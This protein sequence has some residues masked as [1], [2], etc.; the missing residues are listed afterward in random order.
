[1]LQQAM[2]RTRQSDNEEAT[3]TKEMKE[4][5]VNEKGN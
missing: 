5:N 4:D 2:Q 1:M 3:A